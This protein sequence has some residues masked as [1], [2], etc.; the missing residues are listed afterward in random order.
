MFT[1]MHVH[2]GQEMHPVCSWYIYFFIR[3]HAQFLQ[4]HQLPSAA[5]LQVL[6]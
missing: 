1:H 5:W 3:N 4:P 6:Q 2:V